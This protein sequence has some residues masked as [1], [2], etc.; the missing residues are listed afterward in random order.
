MGKRFQEYP[1][2]NPNSF[3]DACGVGFVATTTGK[4][5]SKVLPS[6]I[7][8]LQRLTHR[9]AKSYDGNSGDGSGVLVD[10]PRPFFTSYLRKNCSIK[11]QILDYLKCLPDLADI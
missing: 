6:A 9:G 2:F 11:V 10:I 8:A 5:D 3:H 4:A 1:L 7:S